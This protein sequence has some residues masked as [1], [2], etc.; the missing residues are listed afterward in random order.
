MRFVYLLQAGEHNFPRQIHTTWEGPYS[1][2]L[3]V[4]WTVSK[5]AGVD[6]GLG[7]TD[8]PARCNPR[9]GEPQ[10]NE[11]WYEQFSYAM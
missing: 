10:E 2:A 8:L 11:K 9:I 4:A 1:A 3:Y 5:V 7:L 6:A